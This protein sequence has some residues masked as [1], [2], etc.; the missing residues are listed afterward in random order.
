VPEGEDC[1]GI[2]RELEAMLEDRFDIDHATLQV[3]HQSE[4]LLKIGDVR[5][6]LKPD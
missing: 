6:H 1:H 2:R 3:D 5:T 4:Q